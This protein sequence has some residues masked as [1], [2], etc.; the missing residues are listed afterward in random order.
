MTDQA[1]PS[2]GVALSGGAARGMAHIGVL[3]ALIENQIPIDCIA[4]T[5]AGSIV[6]AGF[7]GGM[8]IDDLEKLGKELRWR[9]VGMPTLSRRGLE[10][11][12]RL[13]RY[14]HK[15]LPITRFE[16]LKI[17]FAAVAT[18]LHSGDA[19][20]MRDHGD[21]PFAVRASCTIPGLY[22]PVVDPQG[23]QLVDGGLVAVIPSAATRE[24]G[25]DI[26]IS[27]DV[28]CDGARFFGS[29]AWHLFGVILQSL[30]VVQKTASCQQ[31][32]NSDVVIRPRI[33]HIRWDQVKRCAEMIEAGYAVG[34]ESIPEILKVIEAK[35]KGQLRPVVV[36]DGEWETSRQDEPE[37]ARV[38]DG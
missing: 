4:G 23:R 25:A 20:V 32:L 19:V 18:D 27:V 5:S 9:H 1:R 37:I 10:S 28:N 15:R 33:G 21:I 8:S 17:P 34:L 30:M 22:V 14:L 36:K 3:R 12:H 6:G 16:D 13:E 35:T 2:I 24:L 38:G 11:N 7:A 31:V 26:V 29:G